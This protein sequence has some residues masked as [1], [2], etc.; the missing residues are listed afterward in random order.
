MDDLLVSARELC[1]NPIGRFISFNFKVKWRLFE[2]MSRGNLRS[3]PTKKIGRVFFAV[4]AVL[5]AYLLCAYLGFYRN[6]LDTQLVGQ[7]VDN[8]YPNWEERVDVQEIDRKIMN[9]DRLLFSKV[10]LIE[11]SDRRQIRF[12]IAYCIPFQHSDLLRDISWV[13]LSDSHGND[14]SDCLTVFPSQIAG[15]YCVAAALT[16]DENTF[17]ALEDGTLTVSLTCA[18]NEAESSYAR[19]EAEIRIP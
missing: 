11:G 5:I 13:K 4:V 3:R 12:R 7:T 17:S 10:Y 19:C 8:H 9:S 15:L 1:Y 2:Y 18:E 6:G 14:Y 16:M